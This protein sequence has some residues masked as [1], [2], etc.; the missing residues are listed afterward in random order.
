MEEDREKSRAHS[1]NNSAPPPGP[2]DL[3]PAMQRPHR[4]GRALLPPLGR[5]FL[6]RGRLRRSSWT[7]SGDSLIRMPEPRHAP[8]APTPTPRSILGRYLLPTSPTHC[9]APPFAPALSLSLSLSLHPTKDNS[10]TSFTSEDEAF[11]DTLQHLRSDGPRAT[12]LRY[13][14]RNRY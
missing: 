13:L 3:P 8:A 9:P 14:L 2:D 11:T 12:T 1:Y 6:S 4:R 7:S 10:C 5:D